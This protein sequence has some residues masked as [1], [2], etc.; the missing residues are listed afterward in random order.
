MVNQFIK[1]LFIGLIS[2]GLTINP[3]LAQTTTTPASNSSTSTDSGVA[4]RAGGQTE[5]QITAEQRAQQAASVA[6][7][8]NSQVLMDKDGNKYAKTTHNLDGTKSDDM[9]ASITGIAIGA[10]A[11]RM[12]THYKT[13]GATDIMVAAAG[14]AAFIAGE[15]MSNMGAKKDLEKQ[16]LE[17]TQKK[18]Q[19][20]QAQIELIQKLKESYENAKKSTKT[21]KTMQMAAAAAFAAAAAMA[22]YTSMNEVAGDV[23]C[24]AAINM[25][26]APLTACAATAVSANPAAPFCKTCLAQLNPYIA[27]FKA[28]EASRGTPGP[29]L[30]VGAAD[31][32]ATSGL[33]TGACATAGP[34]KPLL[35]A[36]DAACAQSLVYKQANT[37]MGPPAPIPTGGFLHRILFPE[38]RITY[39]D[40]QSREIYD[41]STIEKFVNILF[42]TAQAGWM[43]MFGLGAG[44]AAA[45]FL[46]SGP[47]AIQIDSM[48]YVARNRAIMWGGLAALSF[49]A[50]Q[51]SANQIKK[52]EENIAK[53]DKILKDLMNLEKGTPTGKITAQ[54]IA[55][56]V[57][58]PNTIDSQ[59]YSTDNKVKSPCMYS[60]SSENCKSMSDQLEK[61]QGFTEL[62]PAFQTIARD[63]T[64]MADGLSGSK[65]ISG[66]SMAAA[67]NL[68]GKQNA[69]NKMLKSTQGKY[70]Q[71]A[72]KN[73]K[74][75]IDFD[76]A[77]GNFLR[78]A[79]ATVKKSLM[80]KGISAGSVLA[81]TGAEPVNS[82]D[83]GKALPL[84][85]GK[86]DAP[87]AGVVGSSGVAP[88]P[89]TDEEKMDFAF[90][91]APAVADAGAGEAAADNAQYEITGDEIHKDNGPSI[92][93]V[94]S[95]RYLKSGY[96]KL[97]EEEPAPAAKN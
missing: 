25:T 84:E 41:E 80:K 68:A 74:G 93:E 3:V 20:D 34:A 8:S 55:L 65:G 1:T 90:E 23:R 18:G 77:S 31:K 50:M 39:E 28:A 12:L 9:I 43:P 51:S 36:A 19:Q 57:V 54:G 53:L 14:G 26:N 30:S 85:E 7:G 17:V 56:Q 81:S 15:V 70:N 72:K 91:E 35:A 37:V 48:M 21:K 46:I 44:A 66:A 76:K 95:S 27:A 16:T 82:A 92:F 73:G 63:A 89:K 58:D 10:I 40:M 5:N 59:T 94:I 49:L 60:N 79:A 69:I 52:I 96:S 6:A 32:T 61:M 47:L 62:P 87:V 11:A 45:Y 64:K 78:G 24:I 97:L 29:S 13:I 4:G 22:L 88:D 71:I 2:G 38:Q 33:M 42:P 83:L 86:G 67:N 75:A